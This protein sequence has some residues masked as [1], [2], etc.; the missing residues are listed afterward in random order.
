M[1]Q[2]ILLAFPPSPPGD[3]PIG[4]GLEGGPG[5]EGGEHD[6]RGGFRAA[7]VVAKKAAALD[8]KQPPK[9]K[10][11]GKAISSASSSSKGP[12][13][14]PPPLLP[15]PP[16]PI[17]PGP[18]VGGGDSSDSDDIR[19][20]PASSKPPPPLPGGEGERAA[21][22]RGPRKKFIPAIGGAGEAHFHDYTQPGGAQYGNWRFRCAQAC[23]C[24]RTLGLGVRNTSKHG[25]LEPIAFLHV[26]AV[27]PVD[28]AK[29]HIKTNPSPAAVDRFFADHEPELQEMFDW[30]TAP[31][32]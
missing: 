19:I 8:V 18:V 10:A 25:V 5:E 2:D 13:P 6:P 23:R 26:W 14:A 24:I 3:I 17:P 9:A 11:K 15:P 29:G 31:A 12:L 21:V 20:A 32:P 4:E 28:P 1:Q 7:A 27:T 16:A 30:F 22:V